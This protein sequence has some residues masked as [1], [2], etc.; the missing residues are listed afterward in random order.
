MNMNAF[1]Q[2]IL[3]VHY[4]RVNN[5]YE[6]WTLWVWNETDRKAGFE[7]AQAGRDAF[8]IYFD[9]NMGE[10]GLIEKKIGLL[11]KYKNW[12]GKESF[13]RI[14][15]YKGEKE[16]FLKEGEKETGGEKVEISTAVTGVFLDAGKT[17]RVVFN[18]KVGADYLKAEGFYLEAEGVR[19]EPEGFALKD[20]AAY[21]GTV[22]FSFPGLP[23][24]YDRINAGKFVL[25]SKSFEPA[26]LKLGEEAY[27]DN[28]RTD[29]RM[30]VFFEKA[31]TV[32]RAFSPNAVKINLLLRKDP[33]AEKERSSPMRKAG[34]GIWEHEE[35]GDLS[36]QCYRYEAVYSDKKLYGLDPYAE[37]AV[38][39]GK[40][41]LI[42]RD[43]TRV[44]DPP[45][46]E[47]RDTV[48]YEM[49]VRDFTADEFSGVEN[50]GKYLGLAE[51]STRHPRYPEIKTGISHLKELGVNT[52]H[53]LPFQ[54]F[55]NDEEFDKYDWGY[56][57]VRF[58]TPEGWYAVDRKG[59]ARI[60]EL[61]RMISA[62]HENGIR[63]VMD[64]VYNHTAETRNKVYN[65]NALAFDYYY[66]TR[67][68]GTYYNGSGCG[69]EFKTEA[70]MAAKFI[71]D[72][73]LYWVREYKVDGFRFDLMG[74]IDQETAVRIVSEL[75]K[76]RP[77]IL[78]YGEPW[79]A[80]ETPVRGVSKGF[81]KGKEFAVFN[82]DLRDALKGSV[83]EI[84]DLGY[85]QNGS[86]RAKVME[87]IRG[88]LNNFTASPLETIN[89]VSSHDNHTLWDR[90][91]LSVPAEDVAD[92]IKMDK[93][94][95]TVVFV[96]QGI[97]FMLGGEEFLRT[98]H[99]ED[100]SYNLPDSINKI[101]WTRKKEHSGVYRFYR[102]LI[103]LRLSHPAFR[104]RTAEEV[105]KNLKFYENLGLAVKKPGIAFL[106]DGKK[107][108][109][110]WGEILVLINPEKVRR[111]FMLPPGKW[112]LEFDEN[113]F[114]GKNEIFKSKAAVRPVS[115]WVL[116]GE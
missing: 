41:A 97:P 87:G 79:A 78:V 40:C 11:P 17:A 42:F 53:L 60:A 111:N 29:L 13:D 100:N 33:E 109:D 51:E 4:N 114:P 48:I 98:K 64:V 84:K 107:A 37:C 65:F 26:V 23:L 74:L 93:L 82:D 112:R 103:K 50:K 68:D 10:N 36:G 57:P 56:M 101:D 71:L 104:M 30:G 88:S 54:D 28:F 73:L 16:L 69:N 102:D 32:F 24:D 106:I 14:F 90:I 18:R 94:A 115:L 45:P 9:L 113:G 85:V 19:Y 15:E 6:G 76:V 8:G 55:E 99:G 77:D 96:S 47:I 35:S 43:S 91:S 72:S 89:Y 31:K 3:R 86:K 58:N 27:S 61:K 34:N 2:P 1:S 83:F 70:P 62:L 110:A 38:S 12:E 108:G 63:V 81:Q 105:N 39:N 80:G 59:G 66:R 22:C 20:G 95:Q 67:D 25:R 52:L 75:R 92:R 5:N 46:L 21:A 116:S 44:A 49:S 7:L